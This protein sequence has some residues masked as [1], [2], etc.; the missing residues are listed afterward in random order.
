MRLKPSLS[1]TGS[2]GL[3]CML[4]LSLNACFLFGGGDDRDS[5]GKKMTKAEKAAAQKEADAVQQFATTLEVGR[6]LKNAG[7]YDEALLVYFETIAQDS[8]TLIAAKAMN[9]VGDIHIL[10]LQ[11]DKAVASFER[12]LQYFPVFED[13]ENIKKKI[14]FAKAALEVRELR[15]KM[16]KEGPSMK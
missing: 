8:T 16:A 14:E 5:S 10:T 1:M 3:L 13:I 2:I 15:L 4:L 9:E 12:I 11:Y 7:R 6:T